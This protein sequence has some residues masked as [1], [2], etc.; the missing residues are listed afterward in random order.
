MCDKKKNPA[1][2]WKNSHFTVETVRSSRRGTEGWTGLSYNEPVEMMD[3][4]T[5]QM[6]RLFFPILNIIIQF[7]VAET[8]PHMDHA[9]DAHTVNV[10]AEVCGCHV[11]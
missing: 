7:S 8:N 10:T 6:K 3:G 1:N 11:F 5:F 9:D 2:K 4:E